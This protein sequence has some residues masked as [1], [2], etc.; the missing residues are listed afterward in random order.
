M[1]LLA[2]ALAWALPVCAAISPV[3][4]GIV[5]DQ[6]GLEW[7]PVGRARGFSWEM[8]STAFDGYRLASSAEVATLFAHAGITDTFGEGLSDGAR[9]LLLS[10]GA[11]GGDHGSMDSDFWVADSQGELHAYGTL[12]QS[13]VIATGAPHSWIARPEVAFIAGDG[14]TWRGAALVRVS[15]A[16]EPA[17]WVLMLAGLIASAAATTRN[18]RSLPSRRRTRSATA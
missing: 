6:T 4:G 3:P 16:P 5:D 11:L 2:L 13:F 18:R 7:L 10:W 12:A 17:T 15:E 8:A 14:A 1:K 9:T